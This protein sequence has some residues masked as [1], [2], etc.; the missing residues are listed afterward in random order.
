V[1]H[2]GEEIT[3]SQPIRELVFRADGE[4]GVTWE[5]FELYRDYWGTY[6]YDLEQ[7]SLDLSRFS[8]NY[9][10]D[11]AD[12]QGSFSLDEQGRLLLSEIW[13]G[14]AQGSTAHS[15]CGH[16]FVQ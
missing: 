6:T 10:P 11:D 9:V 12:G 5:P 8:G 1:R 16:R 15:N 13:L 7:G 4:F 14:A 2:T 3:P